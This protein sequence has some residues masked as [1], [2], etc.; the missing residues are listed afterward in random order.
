VWDLYLGYCTAAFESGHID[1]V[2]V[3]LEA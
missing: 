3:V 2:H 1:A